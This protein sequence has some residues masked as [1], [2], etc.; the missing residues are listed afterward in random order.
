[1]EAFFNP[2]GDPRVQGWC[3]IEPLTQIRWAEGAVIKLNSLTLSFSSS[4]LLLSQTGQAPNVTYFLF[5][6]DYAELTKLF[7]E[8]D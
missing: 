5:L 8:P 3:Q 6:C 4:F 2:K 1:M 7:L